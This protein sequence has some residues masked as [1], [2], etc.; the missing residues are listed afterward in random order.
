MAAR[1]MMEHDCRELLDLANRSEMPT[2]EQR[3]RYRRDQ[4]YI[5]KILVQA[6]NRL[7]EVAG[8]RGI[9]DSSDLQ[10]FHRDIHAATHHVG[11]TWDPKIQLYGQLRLGAAPDRMDV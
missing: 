1:L 3:V 4:G 10:R 8:G 6:V 5:A 11:L 2:L 7:F 9:Y